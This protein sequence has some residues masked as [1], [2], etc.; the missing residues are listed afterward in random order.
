MART[1]FA[2]SP[3]GYLHI[4]GVR[5]AL[6]NWLYA[7][8]HGGQFIL[9]IDDTDQQ[10]NVEEALAPILH[11]LKWCGITWDEGP[12]VGGPCGPYF[13]SKK[14]AR[15]QEAVRALLDKGLAYHDYATPEES[16]AER[17]AAEKEKRS[18]LYSR[19]WMAE[20]PAERAKWEAQGRQAVVRL[21]MPRE[22]ACR[23]Q[24]HIRGEVK[25]DWITEQDHVIQRADG[26]CLYHLASVVDDFDMKI[27]HVIRAEEHLSNTPRQVF[28]L[29][30][31]GYPRPEYA[32]LPF[33]AEPGSKNKLSKR[34]IA[35]YLKNPDFKK[36]YDHGH[37]I[38]QRLG[39]QTSA[40]TFNPVIVDFFEQVGYL[41]DAVVNYLLLLGWAYDDK[42]EDFTRTEMIDLFD[43]QKV[44]KAPASLDVGKLFAFQDRYM[45]RQSLD[46]KI[47]LTTPYLDKSGIVY[48][49]AMLRLIVQAAGDRIKV[50]GD[51]LDFAFFFQDDNEFPFDEKSFS[52]R[53][54]VGGAAQKL[55]EFRDYIHE[56]PIIDN[57]ETI[58]QQINSIAGVASPFDNE[59]DQFLKQQTLAYLREKPYG[60]PFDQKTLETHYF[61]RFLELRV[62]SIGDVIHAIRVA[63]TG[64][65]TGIGLY[66]TM[67]ILGRE[68]CVKRI[69][70]ALA[71]LATHQDNASASVQNLPVA[72]KSSYTTSAANVPIRLYTGR[73]D[74]TASGQYYSGEGR[75]DIEWLPRPAVKLQLD[76]GSIGSFQRQRQFQLGDASFS[77]PGL[78][79]ND[80]RCLLYKLECTNSNTWTVSGIP[81]GPLVFG[82]GCKL[83][84]VDFHLT[85]F[86]QFRGTPITNGQGAWA[87]RA[88]LT[89]F[90]WQITIDEVSEFRKNVD[91][92]KKSA[93]F[94]ITHIARLEKVDQSVFSSDECEDIFH[95]LQKCLSFARGFWVAPVLCVGYDESNTEVWHD[96]TLRI[97]ADWMHTES[98]F[99]TLEP[100]SLQKLFAS[101]SKK[102]HE[103]NGRETLN[104]A[105]YW[106]LTSNAGGGF[107]DGKIATTQIG[108]ESI[109]YTLATERSILDE[110]DK[111]ALSAQNALRVAL[112]NAMIPSNIPAS[113]SDLVLFSHDFPPADA[114]EVLRRLRNSIVHP[115][116]GN[117]SIAHRV[118]TLPS[119]M[120]QAWFLGLWQLELLILRYL[121]YDGKF[122]SRIGEN[123]RRG[124]SI[125]VPWS[126]D[127]SQ[128]IVSE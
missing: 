51:V 122:E 83:K 34:K 1:R 13:Q 73:L 44:N 87:G 111:N 37:A 106:Y 17:E 75:I 114:P 6:F 10:R 60:L 92:A 62:L 74:L 45:Q 41:P 117:L 116:T 127:A 53:L 15:Y 50:F 124:Q 48:D 9:R 77:V 123:R 103:S 93:G 20:T 76:I 71:L 102:W 68:K 94:A 47:E 113:Y 82:N 11:G 49:D 57:P 21:K 72:L 19:R 40:E 80:V 18:Y 115:A 58:A 104:T 8:K 78:G 99:P 27:T 88:V 54:Q 69:D 95:M 64:K 109:T 25:V 14:L 85:N 26:T 32:H 38:A 119:M 4:G 28:I 61:P 105:V 126:A 112:K 98:W 63:I 70:R 97:F 33:V 91:Q 120:W 30:G 12:D 42:K 121:D 35:Q 56:L 2:P 16:K 96:W 110:S 86:H 66:E 101:F 52:K 84:Y 79:I 89:S 65:G 67:A 128:T 59:Q 55:S 22:G 125:R 31:L 29:E 100:E 46:R 3:T 23:I 36:V 7:K 39:L 107:I 118:K 24:D 43:L 108:L 5:T 81:N 90:G